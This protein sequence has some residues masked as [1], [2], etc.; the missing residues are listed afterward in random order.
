MNYFIVF[1]FFIFSFTHCGMIQGGAVDHRDRNADR[2]PDLGEL[3]DEEFEEV[4]TDREDKIKDS[5][6]KIFKNLDECETATSG[7]PQNKLD[8]L[9]SVFGGEKYNAP[10]KVRTC[11]H[12]KIKQASD[13]LCVAKEQV[14]AERNKY[15]NQ[16]IRAE[17]TDAAIRRIDK[18]HNDYR[19]VLID[20]VKEFKS[21]RKDSNELVSGE[22][23]A[24]RDMLLSE[25]A[26]ECNHEQLRSRLN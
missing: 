9:F 25:A 3:S 5:L 26:V 23:E 21:C 2:L 10:Q 13:S 18:L 16:D 4:I 19:R 22:C 20:G 8:L 11:I 24:L 7:I 15:G 12:Y 14:Y 1:L 17:R 6:K